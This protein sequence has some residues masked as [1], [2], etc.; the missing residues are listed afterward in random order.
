MATSNAKLISAAN[1][2]VID[3]SAFKMAIVYHLR[4]RIKAR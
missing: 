1:A 3:F 4:L 2:V